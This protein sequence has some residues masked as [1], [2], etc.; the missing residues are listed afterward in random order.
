M[1]YR[2]ENGIPQVKIGGEVAGLGKLR[3][4]IHMYINFDT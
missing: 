2:K 3:L 1:V 4:Y